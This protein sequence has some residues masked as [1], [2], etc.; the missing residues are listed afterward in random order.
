MKMVVDEFE[1]LE[2][3]YKAETERLVLCCPKCGSSSLAYSEF[4]RCDCGQKV[5]LGRYD[6]NL[7]YGCGKI[8]SSLGQEITLEAS[9]KSLEQALEKEKG[10][11]S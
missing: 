9:E 7:C 1:C 5:Y 11:E 10:E 3:G 2:C 4:V 8:Y 6:N